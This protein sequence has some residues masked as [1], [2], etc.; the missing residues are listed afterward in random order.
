MESQVLK[1]YDVLRSDLKLPEERALEVV[2]IIYEIAKIQSVGKHTVEIVHKDIQPLKGCIDWKFPIK[3]FE[4]MRTQLA[5]T[6]YDLLKWMLIACI[7][8]ITITVWVILL[9][10]KK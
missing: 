3:D 9:F 6:H 4:D 8:Q 7:S 5:H 1:P 2:K 10:L